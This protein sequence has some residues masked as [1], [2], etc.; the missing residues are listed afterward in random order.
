MVSG[1]TYRYHNIL[2]PIYRK[3]DDAPIA[4]PKYI[5]PAILICL[6]TEIGIARGGFIFETGGYSSGLVVLFP[7][8]EN[9]GPYRTLR[10]KRRMRMEWNGNLHVHI[11]TGID[12]LISALLSIDI[13]IPPFNS[14]KNGWNV[15]EEGRNQE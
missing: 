11:C 7:R 1:L 13:P 12:Y 3:G 6:A 10:R 14:K 4:I 15:R 9:E 2:H 8:H 5:Y